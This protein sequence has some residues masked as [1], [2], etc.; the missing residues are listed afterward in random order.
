MAGSLKFFHFTIENGLTKESCRFTGQGK[1]IEDA[2]KNGIACITAPFR[3]SFSGGKA[4]VP[5]RL[6][7]NSPAIT[8]P[9]N[10]L[11]V[12]RYVNRTKEAFEG[13]TPYNSAAEQ[14]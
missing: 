13:D 10:A 8:D 7:V 14:P 11:M 6:A 2:W 3:P 9:D 5:L 1:S 4:N 12:N